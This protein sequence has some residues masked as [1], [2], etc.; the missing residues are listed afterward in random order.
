MLFRS[1]AYVTIGGAVLT[2]ALNILLIPAFHYT[3]AA[4]ATLCCYA[5]MMVVS[6][7]QGQKYYPI[8]YAKKKLLAYLTI[9]ILL[10]FIQSGILHLLPA[11]LQQNPWLYLGSGVLLTGLFLLLIL[12]V[13]KKELQKLPL[14]G[15]WI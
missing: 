12:R 14:V 6:Y 9:V 5:F 2:I 10:Y 15:K 7:L 1:G 11:A 8:P 13:E 4:W 3:G